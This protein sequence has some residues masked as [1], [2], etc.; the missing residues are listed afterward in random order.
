MPQNKDKVYVLKY[1]GINGGVETIRYYQFTNEPQT[2]HV[3]QTCLK[4]GEPNRTTAMTIENAREH[5]RKCIR[6]G[7]HYEIMM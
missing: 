3:H 6:S 7:Y 5:W 1:I 2:V 4:V